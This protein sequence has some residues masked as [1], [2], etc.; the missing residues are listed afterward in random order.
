MPAGAEQLRRSGDPV[1]DSV[2]HKNRH[3][4]VC[5]YCGKT[6]TCADPRRTYCS[7]SCGAKHQQRTPITE[8][9]REK[10]SQEMRRRWKRGVYAGKDQSGENNSMWRGG[11]AKLVCEVCGKQFTRARSRAREHSCCSKQCSGF[12]RNGEK[13]PMWKG[14]IS[15]EP[16]PIKFNRGLK[17]TIRDRDGH[18]CV[19]CGK[20]ETENKRRLSVHHIDYDKANLDR[21]NL[22]SLCNS[23]NVLVNTDRE[24]WT[25][26]L[27]QLMDN[28]PERASA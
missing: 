9:T 27:N 6:F 5:A 8:A 14:G 16:Y 18:I 24:Y 22:V 1:P 13:S 2:R 10:L 3:S 11:D 4:F 28:H 15:F 12:A 21:E 19:L 7:R 23:C 17:R 20:T 26:W 25:M